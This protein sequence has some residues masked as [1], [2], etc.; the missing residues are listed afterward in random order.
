MANF[1]GIKQ[2]TRAAYMGVSPEDK[3][4]YFWLVSNG[5]NATTATYDIYFG[6]RHYGS[7]NDKFIANVIDVFGGLMDEEGG[8]VLPIEP[9]GEAPFESIDDSNVEDLFGL[10]KAFDAAIGTK[11][12]SEAL[13]NYFTKSEVN[14]ELVKLQE[15]I[16][17]CLKSV[18]V[19]VGDVEYTGVVGENGVATIDLSDA[20]A[21]AGKVQSVTVDGESVV[22]ENGVAAISL[23]GK[24]DVS[25]VEGISSRVGAL[26]GIGHASDVAYDSENK[27]IYLVD[28]D[29][30]QLG[31]GFDASPFIVDGMLDSVSFEEVD[32]VKTNNLVFVFNTD[33]GKQT[34]VVDFSKYVDTYHADETSITLDSST[35]TFSVKAVDAEKVGVDEIPVGGTPLADILL[36]KG[37]TAITAGNLQVVLEGLFSQNLWAENPRRNVP[38]SLSVSMSAPSISLDKS[39]TQ[40]VGTTVNLSASAKTATASAS[41]TYSGF[42]YGYSMEN[43]N[44]KDGDT[45]SSV[46]ISGTKNSDS[47]YKLTFVTNSGFSSV[48]VADV[49]GSTT[50]GNALVVAEGTNKVTV[51][52]SSPTF[53]ATVPGQSKIYA[54]SSLKK[55]D[56]EHVV[57]ASTDTTISGSVKTQTGST[58]ITGAYKLFVGYTDAVVDSSSAIKGLSTHTGWTNGSTEVTFGGG[59]FPGGKTSNIAMPSA[60]SLKEV[61]NG[62]ELDITNNFAAVSTV[63][64]VLP[65]ESEIEYKVYSNLYGADVAYN[66]IKIGK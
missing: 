58:S 31:D 56:E 10:L 66:S 32:G 27:L 13:S 36:G 64:Y 29:G 42:T 20:F 50:S 35:N 17:A 8:F 46:S 4:G 52:A 12:D 33:S 19:K 43:D 53:S 7:S 15:A 1:L 9:G 25:V 48:D 3:L 63:T 28:E 55:T 21:A 24:A 5:D 60:W 57:S 65:D 18:T 14:A 59:T 23:S 37:V 6:T 62:M 38:T 44:T 11:A 39:G 41:I 54:C 2:V 22:D 51:T 49:T 34:M 16:D 30:N 61:K 40:E 47:D 45:P 26:E